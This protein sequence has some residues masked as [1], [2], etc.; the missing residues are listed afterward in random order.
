MQ[1]NNTAATT[2]RGI[3]GAMSIVSIRRESVTHG[4]RFFGIYED[5]SERL[6]RKLATRPYTIAA[7][8]DAPVVSKFIN[9]ACETSR[10]DDPR[11]YITM[12]SK[13]PGGSKWSKILKLIPIA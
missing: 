4:F 13:T 3:N 8:H 7:I 6:L 5:G 11:C 2:T 12:H 9:H 1:E 10:C